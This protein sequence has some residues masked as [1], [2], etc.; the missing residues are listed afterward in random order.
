MVII[1]T[2]TQLKDKTRNLVQNT[3]LNPQEVHQMYFFE[4]IID[5]ISRSEYASDFVLKGGLLISAL[6]GV[7]NRTTHDLDATL[8]GTPISREQFSHMM[9]AILSVPIDDNCSF[10]VKSIDQIRMESKYPDYRAHIQVNFG[11]MTNILQLDVTTGDAITPR[12]MEFHYPSL[13][14]D[15]KFLIMAYPLETILA[16]KYETICRRG[17]TTTRARD[18]YDIYT[19]Y[20]VHGARIDWNVLRSAVQATAEN[21]GSEATLPRYSQ[22]I[23]SIRQSDE[24][25]NKIWPNYCR[26]NRYVDPD[27]LDKSLDIALA[28]GRNLGFEPEK[29]MDLDDELARVEALRAQR[30][31]KK[32]GRKNTPA[33]SS[34]KDLEL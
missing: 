9:D 6:N 13:F 23:E 14:S 5:R 25:R 3:S 34:E 21:R 20:Q 12:E 26:D 15:H 28:I 2:A 24:I 29:T 31:A 4:R 7:S 22:V 1:K 32:Q 30:L 8:R 19:L 33:P 16:E 27:A 11:T 10:E 17:D 18:F